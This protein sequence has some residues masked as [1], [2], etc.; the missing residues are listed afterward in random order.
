MAKEP[1]IPKVHPPKERKNPLVVVFWIVI[2]V[3]VLLIVLSACK[4]RFPLE[5][6]I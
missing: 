6:G 4:L 1:V 2:A 3:I 5:T